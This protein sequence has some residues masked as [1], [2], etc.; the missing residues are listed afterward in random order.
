MDKFK[1][2]EKLNILASKET[3]EERHKLIFEWIKTD[4]ITYAEYEEIMRYSDFLYIKS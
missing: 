2:K 3:L 4:V 1:V